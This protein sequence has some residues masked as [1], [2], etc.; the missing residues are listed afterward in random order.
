MSG[1]RWL[2]VVPSVLAVA[3]LLV[4]VGL[5]RGWFSRSTPSVADAPRVDVGGVRVLTEEVELPWGIAFL[6]DGSALITERD[7]ARLLRVGTDGSVREEQRIGEA[8]PRGEGGLLGVAV[9]PTYGTDR[10]VYVYYTAED[11]NR[12][13]RLRLGERPQ[14]ILTGIPKAGNH[15]GGRLAFGPDGMLYAGTGDAAD[16]SRS[17]DRGDLGGKILRMTPEGR[18]APGNPFPDSVVWSYGHR[19][20][21]GLAWDS[22]GRM[23]ASEFGQNTYDEL[24]LITPGA[25]Y[26][27]PE[28]EGTGRDRRFVDPIA[29]WSPAD[30]S[31]SGIAVVGD[32]VY[33]A[34]LRGAR[35]YRVGLDGKGAQTLLEGAYGR[36]RAVASAPDGSLW[37]LTS[38]KD[39][40]GTPDRVLRLPTE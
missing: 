27:W 26:G 6:P 9:A 1:R 25:N 2:V 15:N 38:N 14:P 31:P 22:A 21:Q 19:N 12:I 28:V 23:Y 36:L 39:K 37:V 11:D 35:L 4:G 30:A 17:Q 3:A 34:C 40:L 16:T 20:V 18:P 32:L 33:V 13:A 8:R 10:W 29:T 24:N 5:A 7:S